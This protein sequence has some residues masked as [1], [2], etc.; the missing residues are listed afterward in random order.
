[1][2]KRRRIERVEERADGV[3]TMPNPDARSELAKRID[4]YVAGGKTEAE[5]E[6]RLKACLRELAEKGG[7]IARRPGKPDGK[8]VELS[9]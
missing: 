1:M 3:L 8:H 9:F 7:A 6:E 5:R 2:D 4:R